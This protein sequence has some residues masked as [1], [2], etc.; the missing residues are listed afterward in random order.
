MSGSFCARVLDGRVPA[1]IPD[2]RH[3]PQTAMLDVT[4]ELQIGSY[5]GVPLLGADGSADGMLC[6]TSSRAMPRLSERD[7]T[8]LR[9]LA[10]L[11]HDLQV[12]ALD[13]AA[14]ADRRARLMLELEDVIHGTGR[15]AVLQP[16]VEARSGRVV[17]YEG[18]SRFTSRRTPAEWFDVAARAEVSER[19]ELSAAQTMVDLLRDGTVPAPAALAVNLSPSTLL[20]TDLS[21]LLCDVDLSRVIVEVTEHQPVVDYGRLLQVLAPWRA[22]GLRLAIDDAGAGYASLRHVLMCQPDLMKLDM[23]LVRDLDTDPVRRALLRAVLAFAAESG[24]TVIAEGVETEDERAV[25]VELGVPLLQ[26]YLLGAP[27]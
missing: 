24:I 15:R 27:A 22:A 21:T 5:L 8:T 6:V 1:L 23:A 4:R 26:G 10:R 9:L 19:L 11:L 12:R 17:A 16:I 20:R 2:A 13:E 14:V 25:L 7:L 3:E 18:L